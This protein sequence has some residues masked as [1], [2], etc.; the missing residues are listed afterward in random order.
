MIAAITAVLNAITAAIALSISV[1][2]LVRERKHHVKQ[3]GP[4]NH[5]IRNN[6]DSP[7]GNVSHGSP[8]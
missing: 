5:G 8:G 3:S 4:D 2:K 7:S 1:S 6:S